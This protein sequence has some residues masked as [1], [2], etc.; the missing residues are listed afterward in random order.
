[1]KRGAKSIWRY[2][3]IKLGCL[4]TLNI[5]AGVYDSLL[6]LLMLL[7]FFLL[8]LWFIFCL[9]FR[10]M[11]CTHQNKCDVLLKHKECGS[12]SILFSTYSASLSAFFF[13]F[14]HIFTRL[15]NRFSILLIVILFFFLLLWYFKG[16]HFVCCQCAAH[17]LGCGRMITWSTDW[18][19]NENLWV[20]NL[21][22]LIDTQFY[23]LWI[24]FYCG[25][26][27]PFLVYF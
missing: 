25:F 10:R 14:S 6:P 5:G 19:L 13:R 22:H 18:L 2:C 7:L 11:L 1:M 3:E 23:F 24:F 4:S 8:L 9:V 15:L 17:D 21:Y 16:R 27:I 12:S 20:K 26:W